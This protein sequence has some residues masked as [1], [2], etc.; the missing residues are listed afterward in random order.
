MEKVINNTK[1]NV[2]MRKLN[3]IIGQS[4][5][6][7]NRSHFEEDIRKSLH[8]AESKYTK[9]KKENIVDIFKTISIAYDIN[10]NNKIITCILTYEIL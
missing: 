3:V 9:V 6:S 2:N 5:L 10:F 7:P 4:H 8:D 1:H